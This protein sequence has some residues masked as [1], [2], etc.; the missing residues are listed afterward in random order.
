MCTNK[1]FFPV[2][3]IFHGSPIIVSKYDINLEALGYL[4]YHLIET[5]VCY[6]FLIVL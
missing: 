3:V 1:I 4:E 5:V 6:C 2:S